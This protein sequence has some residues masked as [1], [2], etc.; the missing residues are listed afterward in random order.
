MGS[1]KKTSHKKEAT[2]KADSSATTKDLS[3]RL[4]KMS[5]DY[6]KHLK[7]LHTHVGKILESHGTASKKK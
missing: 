4:D 5:R 3:K 6:K 7:V 2:K 1:D